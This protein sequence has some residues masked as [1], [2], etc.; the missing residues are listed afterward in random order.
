MAKSDLVIVFTSADR[1]KVAIA[2]SLLVEAQ[3]RYFV[4]SEAA[5]DLFV[6]GAL[7]GYNPLVGPVEIQVAEEDA[8]R[9]KEILKDLK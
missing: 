3:I 8:E 7:G 5:Q 6:L 4:K 1:G 9:A 2:K